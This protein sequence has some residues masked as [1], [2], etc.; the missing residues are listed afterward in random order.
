MRI[1]RRFRFEAAHRLPLHEGK[2]R[3]QHGH[4]YVLDVVIDGPIEYL[5]CS[6]QGMVMD[7]KELKQLVE[8]SIIEACDHYDLNVLVDRTRAI[9]IGYAESS[10]D[11]NNTTAELLCLA[12]ARKLQGLLSTKFRL[13]SVR[14]SETEGS[15]AEWVEAEPLFP[16]SRKAPDWESPSKV[17]PQ[18][19]NQ[20]A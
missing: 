1:G 10:E 11:T 7:F 3:R 9:E 12:F 13:V 6:S 14:L 18:E 19:E 16:P 20:H 17:N 2:C 4:S 5:R 8:N 15:W